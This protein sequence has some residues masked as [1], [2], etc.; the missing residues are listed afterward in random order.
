MNQLTLIHRTVIICDVNIDTI[1]C[2]AN[3][4]DKL[5]SKH[6][7]TAAEARQVLLNH[8]RIRFGEKGHTPGE[9]VYAALGQTFG[10][11]YLAVFFVYKP[12]TATA[13]IISARDMTTSERKQY[14]RK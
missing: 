2:P 12:D 7:V 13:I 1:V 6:H 10:G 11:R 5:E 9:D 8:P 4:E 14:G 3:V